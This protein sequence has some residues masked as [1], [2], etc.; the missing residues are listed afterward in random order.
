M[1]PI[2]ELDEL[3]SLDP[4]GVPEGARSYLLPVL[5]CRELLHRPEL[6]ITFFGAFKAGKTSLLNA[7]VG[8]PLLPTR[9]NRATGA[10][11]RLQYAPQP[12]ASVVRDGSPEKVFVPFDELS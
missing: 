11:T 9:A 6:Q 1:K 4:E 2:A 10:V 3:L 12:Y 5:A 8:A 7:F